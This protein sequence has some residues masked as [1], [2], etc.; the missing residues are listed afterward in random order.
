[1]KLQAHEE[2][3]IRA[4]LPVWLEGFDQISENSGR[5]RSGRTNGA[6]KFR[7]PT[8]DDILARHGITL[9]RIFTDP[10]SRYGLVESKL[11]RLGLRIARRRAQRGRGGTSQGSP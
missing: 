5:K 7:G 8:A 9:G 1:M 4:A 3:A 11:R 10:P 6:R 2:R